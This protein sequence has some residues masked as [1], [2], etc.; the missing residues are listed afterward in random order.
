MTQ[1]TRVGLRAQQERT[2]APDRVPAGSRHV[3]ADVLG[4]LG[5]LSGLPAPPQ[6][7]AQLGHRDVRDLREDLLVG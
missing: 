6:A 7:S 3:V 2:S 4:D 1:M 5:G